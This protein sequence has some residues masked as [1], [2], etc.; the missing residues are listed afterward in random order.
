[1][2]E[3][4]SKRIWPSYY[5]L[6]DL[7]EHNRGCE[8]SVWCAQSRVSEMRRELDA[9]KVLLQT[10]N[11]ERDVA[12]LDAKDKT[13]RM[14]SMQGRFDG[15]MKEKL[16]WNNCYHHQSCVWWASLTEKLMYMVDGDQPHVY[17]QKF[18]VDKSRC[19]MKRLD[20]VRFGL[21]MTMTEDCPPEL[22]ASQMAEQ[23]RVAIL[24][25]WQHQSIL[26]DRKAA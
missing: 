4:I 25:K 26:L 10:S 13:D 24:E 8:H 7:D 17:Y 19:E 20:I 14:L 1:M 22:V 16:D 6:L 15:L 2:F 12:K 21:S 23:V 11:K 5:R 18:F 3:W 9:T